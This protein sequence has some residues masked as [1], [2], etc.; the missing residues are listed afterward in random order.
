MNLLLII[1]HFFVQVIYKI[2]SLY[3]KPKWQEEK[4][5]ISCEPCNGRG[6]LLCDFCNGQKTNVKSP[7]NRIYRRCPTCKAVSN[8]VYVAILQVQSIWL[9]VPI[10]VMGMIYSVNF[11]NMY[12]AIN[13]HGSE[14]LVIKKNCSKFSV[15]T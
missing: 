2:S 4:I 15:T 1:L 11:H 9:S 12:Y 8:K 3:S 13:T 7:T 6:W 10:V 14:S 5:G